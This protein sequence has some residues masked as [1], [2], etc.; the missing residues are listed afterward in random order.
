M[1]GEGTGSPGREKGD[2]D[3]EGTDRIA[4]GDSG[5]NY[6]VHDDNAAAYIEE[7]HLACEDGQSVDNKGFDA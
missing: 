2:L 1:Q 7:S 4:T 6:A 5:I 3:R